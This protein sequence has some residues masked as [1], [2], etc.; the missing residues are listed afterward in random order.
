MSHFSPDH[1]CS[2]SA[3]DERLK[4][5][6]HHKISTEQRISREELAILKL[7]MTVQEENDILDE[8]R[9]VGAELKQAKQRSIATSRALQAASKLVQAVEQEYNE[10]AKEDKAME[11]SFK[12]RKELADQEA[13][14]DVLFRIY[15]RRPKRWGADNV[16]LAPLEKEKDCPEGLDDVIWRKFLNIRDQKI[17]HERILHA[18]A[19]ELADAGSFLKR[20]KEED[21]QAARAVE[22]LLEK[23]AELEKQRA[24]LNINVE[25][26]VTVKQGQVELQHTDDFDPRFEDAVLLPKSYIEDLN[27]QIRRLSQVLICSVCLCRCAS[28]RGTGSH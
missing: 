7:A 14:M 19:A 24:M 27:T 8:Q 16:E 13:F 17:A 10:I 12:A 1:V 9:R 5:L 22:L 2:V 18:K 28:S 11:K 26:L 3:F 21:E 4:V 25:V 15:R 20:R 23:L 6:F